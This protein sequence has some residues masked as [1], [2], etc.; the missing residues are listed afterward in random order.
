M[1]LVLKH[2]EK[3]RSGKWQ[4][5]R[6]VPK[7][8]AGTI[9]KREFKR[10]LG[11]TERAALI[12]WPRYHAEVERQIAQ[13]QRSLAATQGTAAEAPT[14]REVYAQA[15]ALVT[16]MRAL[17][18]DE[19]GLDLAADSILDRYP[20]DRE[21]GTPVGVSDFDRF[22]VNLL[23]RGP[24]NVPAPAPTLEDA[25]RLYGQEKGLDTRSKEVGQGVDRALRRVSDALGKPLDE[26]PLAS[27][28]RED[29]RKVRDH[30][31]AMD[32]HGASGE[33]L[34]TESVQ[35]DLNRIKAVVN[36][37]IREFDL[38]AAGVT[39]PF[40][41]LPVAKGA[42]AAPGASAKSKRLPLP[43]NLITAMRGRLTGDLLLIWRLLEGTGCRGSEVSGL[44]V[45]DVRLK[46]ACP[47]IMVVWHEGR[48]V[49]VGSSLRAVP[50]VGDALEAAK[51]AVKAA[52]EGLY[53]FPRYVRPRGG[54]AVSAA[55]MK[56]LKPL[57]TDRRHVVNSLRHNLT[58]RLRLAG[59]T[60]T[61]EDAIIGHAAPSVGIAHYGS[62]RAALQAA[63]A[64]MLKALPPGQTPPPRGEVSS[65]SGH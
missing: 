18:G 47:H 63:Y 16:D 45:E 43:A 58:D 27:L 6:R 9:P 50:L 2:V 39:N 44:R 38:G 49:K 41:K 23:R 15:A 62:E 31:L 33:K 37:G 26:V 51:E 13:A 20:E 12:A 53:L 10:V 42:D 5:R 56:H 60:K 17:G 65:S 61:D 29:A 14:Q 25:R 1:G 30:L 52:G 7:E 55:I 54:D 32:R 59:V 11:D 34:T 19:E 3:T 8:L 48:R 36:F 46:D 21:T 22:T 24:D 40:E 64:A 4:Y 57:R 28:R 35:R